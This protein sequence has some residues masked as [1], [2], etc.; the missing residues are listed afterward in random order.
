MGDYVMET[1]IGGGLLFAFGVAA[2]Y[3]YGWVGAIFCMAGLWLVL[4]AAYL[5]FSGY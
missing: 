4:M 5:H 1:M 3:V 2:T